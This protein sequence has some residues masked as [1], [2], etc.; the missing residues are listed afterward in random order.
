MMSPPVAIMMVKLMFTMFPVSLGR[1]V[2][3]APQ[4]RNFAAVWGSSL[5]LPA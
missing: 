4:L 2:T 1:V 3:V 5:L